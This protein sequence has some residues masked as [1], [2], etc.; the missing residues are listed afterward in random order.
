MS[1]SVDQAITFLS[2]YDTEHYTPQCRE[3]HRM[4]IDAIRQ[5]NELRAELEERERVVIQ[6]RK[7]WQNAETH[8]CTMCGHFDHKVDGN[9]VY[10]NRKCG[11]IVG[12]PF[13]AG[14]FTPCIPEL[15]AKES[16]G[17]A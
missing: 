15:P 7:Q 13:C 6:L 4:A 9:I 10:G 3:A 11:E 12:Y 8:I 2:K 5:I 17:D 16:S 14:K 1:I